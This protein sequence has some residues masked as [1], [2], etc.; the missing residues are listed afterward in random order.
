MTTEQ[1]LEKQKKKKSLGNEKL[2]EV[3]DRD[4]LESIIWNDKTKEILAEIYEIWDQIERKH[5]LELKPKVKELEYEI[6]QNIHKH[7]LGD[8]KLVLSMVGDIV[9][10][11]ITRDGRDQTLSL[12]MLVKNSLDKDHLRIELSNLSSWNVQDLPEECSIFAHEVLSGPAA[13]KGKFPEHFGKRNFQEIA[14]QFHDSIERVEELAERYGIPLPYQRDK[15]QD[16]DKD[17]VRLR[18]ADLSQQEIIRL[19]QE[20]IRKQLLGIIDDDESA[21]ESIEKYNYVSEDFETGR[22][23]IFTKE[24]KRWLERPLKDRKWQRDWGEWC[25]ILENYHEQGGT[26]ASSKSAVDS[27]LID[28]KTDKPI[29]RKITKEQ[30][31]ATH[32]EY[33]NIMRFM[34]SN[35]RYGGKFG[36]SED[37]RNTL[38]KTEV[39]E[40]TVNGQKTGEK[41]IEV[42]VYKFTHEQLKPLDEGFNPT[43]RSILDEM[44]SLIHERPELE[45][46]FINFREKERAFRA[47]R[48]IELNPVLSDKA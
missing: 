27:T 35:L 20:K 12:R 17:K 11:K 34:I 7:G 14:Q 39:Y 31:D 15:L 26:F 42:E 36:R 28:P 8:N 33:L 24:A 9:L 45:E 21:L 2:A 44:R 3:S 16:E 47:T 37:R 32:D 48:A 38:D 41:Y 23:S 18:I 4:Q 6:V 22:N 29:Q 19:V 30:I 46:D 1:E 43:V 10:K 13:L 5:N 25:D 40:I